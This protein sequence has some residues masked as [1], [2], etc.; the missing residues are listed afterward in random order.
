[1]QFRMRTGASTGTPRHEV[2]DIKDVAA[3]CNVCTVE[4]A[5]WSSAAL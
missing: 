3:G 1:M 4:R 2:S 5:T